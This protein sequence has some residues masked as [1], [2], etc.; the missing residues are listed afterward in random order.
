M[1]ETEYLKKQKDLIDSGYAEVDEFQYL[2]TQ[3][4]KSHDG[5]QVYDHQNKIHFFVKEK[6]K[7]PV[8]PPPVVPDPNVD[9]VVDPNKG[10]KGCIYSSTPFTNKTEGDDFRKWVRENFNDYA[11]KIDLSSTGEFNNCNYIR[12]AYA[13]VMDGYVL[14]L[15]EIYTRIKKNPNLQISDFKK[16]NYEK[17]KEREAIEQTYSTDS[18]MWQDL[19]DKGELTKYGQIQKLSSGIAVYVL[20]YIKGT[21]NVVKDP[22]FMDFSVD[23]IKP[24]LEKYDF[25]VLLPPPD[26]NKKPLKGQI[27]LIKIKPDVNGEDSVRIVKEKGSYWTAFQDEMKFSVNESIIQNILGLLGENIVR[28]SDGDNDVATVGNITRNPENK[29]TTDDKKVEE[30]KTEV[31][32]LTPQQKK[33]LDSFIDMNKDMY[34][35]MESSQDPVTKNYLLSAYTD[36][37]KILNSSEH[38]VVLMKDLPKKENGKEMI[39]QSATLSPSCIV[40]QRTN[41]VNRQP[42]QVKALEKFFSAA[43]LNLTTTAPEIGGLPLNF[44]IFDLIPLKYIQDNYKKDFKLDDQNVKVWLKNYQKVDTTRESCRTAVKTLAACI[45]PSR[46]GGGRVCNNLPTI[47]DYKL[48]AYFCDK[49]AKGEKSYQGDKEVGGF[50]KGQGRYWSRI[51]LGKEMDLIR[52]SA[53]FQNSLYSIRNMYM[54]NSL[55]ENISSKLELAITEKIDKELSQRIKNNLMSRLK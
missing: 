27:G 34:Q 49:M 41:I 55:Y 22:G 31:C 40:Y 29:L 20:K 16:E 35:A 51:G 15:G 18:K 32:V 43:T 36:T 24:D 9:P 12:K 5:L 38:T 1:T 47:V 3:K 2:L 4:N 25:V 28:N 53:Q 50:F 17:T 10:K 21:D 48:D 7:K 37:T 23:V 14:S 26:R 46:K 6:K 8:T 45:D 19:I 44:K 39:Y 33:D 13:N 52:N 30:K 42:D 54:G 11:I